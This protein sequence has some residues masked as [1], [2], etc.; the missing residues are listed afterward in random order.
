[1]FKISL[2]LVFVAPLLAAADTCR[3]IGDLAEN[4]MAFRQ[5]GAPL[6]SPMARIKALD[7]EGHPLAE[8][9]VMT[10]YQ[11]PNLKYVPHKTMVIERFRSESEWRCYQ[12]VR[13]LA[14]RSE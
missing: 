11:T 7:L 1:M 8:K 10:A 5:Q 3:A 6:S 2:A 13:H 4:A 9:I 14:S 12:G